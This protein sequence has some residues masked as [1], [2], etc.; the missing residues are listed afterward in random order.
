MLTEDDIKELIQASKETRIN[1]LKMV[2][3][4]KSGHPGYYL[5]D[6]LLRF[7]ILFWLNKV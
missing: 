7:Y 6:M 3:N 5:K 4:A 1:I 2:Y